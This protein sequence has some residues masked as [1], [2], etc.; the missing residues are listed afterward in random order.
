MGS[1]K[2]FSFAKISA[3]EGTAFSLHTLHVGEGMTDTVLVI[4]CSYCE[5]ADGFLPMLAFK[6][7]RFV[8]FTCAHT[9]RFDRDSYLC[10]CRQC[11]R[12]SRLIM[13]DISLFAL[14]VIGTA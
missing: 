1:L 9:V 7:G 13:G 8:C 6:D 3:V 10:A 2:V 12:I 4:R 11:V 14:Q 5:V